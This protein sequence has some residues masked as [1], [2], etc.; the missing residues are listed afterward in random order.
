MT[1]THRA[2]HRMLWPI[3]A[4]VVAVGIA[5]AFILHVPAT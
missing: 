4:V 3:L 5:L 2:F 1:R